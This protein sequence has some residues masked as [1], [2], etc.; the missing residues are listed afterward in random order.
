MSRRQEG[1]FRTHA[2]FSLQAHQYVPLTVTSFN[3][4][5]AKLSQRWRGISLK[6]ELQQTR[7]EHEIISLLVRLAHDL[8]F[9]KQMTIWLIDWHFW[10]SLKLLIKT[11]MSYLWDLWSRLFPCLSYCPVCIRLNLA[12]FALNVQKRWMTRCRLTT[13]RSWVR[14]PG[15]EGLSVFLRKVQHSQ[16]CKNKRWWKSL[17]SSCKAG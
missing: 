10:A 7:A 14:F 11:D 16:I 13:R 2:A 1:A 8:L 5:A 12:K 17:P 15:G 9:H 4:L 6:G 3:R